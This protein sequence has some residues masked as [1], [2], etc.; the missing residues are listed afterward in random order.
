MTYRRGHTVWRGQ[1]AERGWLRVRGQATDRSARALHVHLKLRRAP[2]AGAG[3]VRQRAHLLLAV[4]CCAL[5][6]TSKKCGRPGWGG[7]PCGGG[8][9]MA[10]L[11][12]PTPYPCGH[13]HPSPSQKLSVAQWHPLLARLRA[14]VLV[15]LRPKSRR[16]AAARR[17]RRPRRVLRQRKRQ[18]PPLSTS[19]VGPSAQPL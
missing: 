4:F 15:R 3:S 13:H 5:F 19:L 10:T 16:P 12:S 14:G 18:P 17:R 7:R 1:S 9:D 2:L 11:A 6:M 8:V